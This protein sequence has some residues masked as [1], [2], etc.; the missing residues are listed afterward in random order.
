[1]SS[2][3]PDGETIADLAA[4]MRSAGNPY[5][6]VV[7]LPHRTVPFQIGGLVRVDE[8]DYDPDQVL[9]ATRAALAQ[10]FGFDA[11]GLGQGV[12]QSEVVAAIQAVP[13]VVAVRLTEFSREDVQSNLPEFLIATAPVAGERG[14]VAGAELLQIDVLSLVG[15]GRWP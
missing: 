2:L 3:D 12:A 15:L 6:P 10:A 7:V 8:T 13:G 14:I 5:V 1:G 9:A 11:R 4:A